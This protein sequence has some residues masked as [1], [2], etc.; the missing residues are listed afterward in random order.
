MRN[1]IKMINQQALITNQQANPD[2]ALLD[3]S[4]AVEAEIGR[5]VYEML[6]Q[7]LR[8]EQQKR[9]GQQSRSMTRR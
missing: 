9:G 4:P 6:R 5:L 1:N 7:E 2:L 8:L 3:L